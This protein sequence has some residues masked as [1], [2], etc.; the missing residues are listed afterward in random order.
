MPLV[1]SYIKKLSN[2]KPGKPIEEVKRELG[3]SNIIKLASN[4]NPFG[5]SPKAI[6]AIQSNIHNF[7]RYPD[8]SGYDLRTKLAKNFNV[9]ID[10]VVIGAGSE[11]I[12]STI[13]RTFLLNDDQL[14]GS[15][16]SF[17][18][19]KVLANASG[20][21]TKWVPMKD[22]RYDLTGM[23]KQINDYTKIIYIANPDNP[24]GTFI[25]KD[26]FDEFYSYVPPRALII[27]DE[28]YFE[29]AKDIPEYPD[30]MHYR[31]NNVITL[32]SFSKAYGLGGLRIGYGFAHHDLISNLMKVKVPFEPSIPAQIAGCAALEDLDFLNKTLTEN[33]NSLQYLQSE[34]DKLE[35]LFLP[36]AANFITTIWESED[37]AIRIVNK[38]MEDGIIVRHLKSFGR[39]N[40][41]RISTGLKEENKR[42]ISQLKLIL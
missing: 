23:A 29:F 42:L 7:H 34:L 6:E 32:R 13:M 27:L 1:P 41:I 9:K 20:R 16:N 28:A 36:S 40:Y 26:E 8:A 4:E 18:G 15:E 12:M 5:P 21:L 25:T 2:Y 11:G 3:I 22:N 35:V 37:E 39:P 24:M 14:I 30:S 10:N 19:F 31:Y 17:I 38:L 33:N